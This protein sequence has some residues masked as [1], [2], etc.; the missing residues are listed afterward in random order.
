L[1]YLPLKRMAMIHPLDDDEDDLEY[2]ADDR[3]RG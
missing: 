3:H 2:D 1:I